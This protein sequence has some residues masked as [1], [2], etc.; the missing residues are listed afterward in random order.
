MR[1]A[2]NVSRFV[3][4][5]PIRPWAGPSEI[6]STFWSRAA[7]AP[8]SRR[9]AAARP[10]GDWGGAE[11][12]AWTV[13]RVVTPAAVTCSAAPERASTDRIWVLTIGTRC[14]GASHGLVISAWAA[15]KLASAASRSPDA[16]LPDGVTGRSALEEALGADLLAGPLRGGDAGA[17]APVGVH[18]VDAD[19][20]PPCR[21]EGHRPGGEEAAPEPPGSPRRRSRGPRP[22][23]WQAAGIIGRGRVVACGSVIQT[24]RRIHDGRPRLLLVI[25][26]P[27]SEVGLRPV[28]RRR[29]SD[30]RRSV[31]RGRGAW[32]RGCGQRV[33]RESPSAWS[34]SAGRW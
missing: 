34:C 33:R 20:N 17:Q 4:S 9:T 1:S 26:R 19:H 13:A 32:G 22:R 2:A 16:V 23:R 11:R 14:N 10:A 6:R 30:S 15:V 8:A 29:R 3:T 5:V 24:R 21:H 28:R 31:L 25:L 12:T 7:T 27:R 18:E